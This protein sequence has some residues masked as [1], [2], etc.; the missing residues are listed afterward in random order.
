MHIGE[1]FAADTEDG[2]SAADETNGDAGP[3]PLRVVKVT[4]PVQVNACQ[5][6][7]YRVAAYS[8]RATPEEKRKVRWEI[9][10]A[11]ESNAIPDTAQ[12]DGDTLVLAKV[13]EE[14]SGVVWSGRTIRVYAYLDGPSE[15]ASADTLVECSGICKYIAI[16]RKVEQATGWDPDTVL[17]ALRRLAGY[18]TEKWQRLYG[19]GPARQLQPVGALSAADIVRLEGLSSHGVLGSGK[20]VG[21]VADSLRMPVAIGHVLTGLSAG[22]HRDRAADLRPWYGT[23]AGAGSTLDNLYAATLAGDV[24]Q[25]AVE[26]RRDP[27]GAR[28]GPGSELTEAEAIGD[29]DGIIMGEEGGLGGQKVSERLHDYYCVAAREPGSNAANRFANFARFMNEHLQDESRRFAVVY[30]YSKSAAQGLV[31]STVA[32]V[33]EVLGAFQQWYQIMAEREQ[34]GPRLLRSPPLR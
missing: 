9:R 29:M 16:V 18:D 1:K 20:E 2:G 30:L 33:D 8:R 25:S 3:P 12:R 24:G 28:M 7:T 27:G 31:G 19:L 23:A 34:P 22:Q 4:G 17:N 6:A 32:E 10:I 15:K 5:E 26:V 14:C 13:P 21:V 11:G